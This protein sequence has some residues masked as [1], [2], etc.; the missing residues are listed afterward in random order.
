[1][2]S[3][4]CTDGVAEDPRGGELQAVMSQRGELGSRPGLPAVTGSNSLHF[5]LTLVPREAWAAG[6]RLPQG[7][8]LLCLQA[9]HGPLLP[10]WA[11]SP[12]AT[13]GSGLSVPGIGSCHLRSPGSVTSGK[14]SAPHPCSL[15]SNKRLKHGRSASFLQQNPLLGDSRIPTRHK[16]RLK[17]SFRCKQPMILDSYH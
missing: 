3:P 10:D 6:G 13:C 2:P 7:G 11:Q 9:S 17:T 1:M 14:P 8:P 12:H 16:S 15:S 5:L 4:H